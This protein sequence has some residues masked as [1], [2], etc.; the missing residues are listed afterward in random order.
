MFS[1]QG[2]L[3]DWDSGVYTSVQGSPSL[4]QDVFCNVRAQ[5]DLL[6]SGIGPSLQ[7][8]RRKWESVVTSR[9]LKMKA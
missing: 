7:S 2:T 5:T 4:T 9:T 3:N 6:G 8:A 1:S